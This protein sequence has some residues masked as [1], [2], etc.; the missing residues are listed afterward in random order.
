VK[1]NVFFQ[2]ISQFW[3]RFARTVPLILFDC[4]KKHS[5]TLRHDH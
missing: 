5:W 3:Q 2:Q 4:H 1:L